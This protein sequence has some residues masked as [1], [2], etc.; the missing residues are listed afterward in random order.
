MQKR[1][2]KQEL[3]LVQFCF[4]L[5]KIV[6]LGPMPSHWWNHHM[7]SKIL[8]KVE[9]KSHL[10][11]RRGFTHAGLLCF[12]L[13]FKI[14]RQKVTDLTKAFSCGM[15]KVKSSLN[16]PG[17]LLVHISRIWFDTGAGATSPINIQLRVGPAVQHDPKQHHWSLGTRACK[18]LNSSSPRRTNLSKG[19]CQQSAVLPI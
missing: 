9:H 4:T 13:Y 5:G 10:G 18:P 19:T 11:G 15:A 8:I 2:K 6:R 1:G 12:C 7:I 17:F 14:K 16:R 3:W